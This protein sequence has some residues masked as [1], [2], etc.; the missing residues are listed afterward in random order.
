LLPR[1]I[2]ENPSYLELVINHYYYN[3]TSATPTSTTSTP[4]T[5]LTFRQL[6]ESI[7]KWSVDLDEQEKIFLNQATSVAAWDR[8]LVSNGEKVPMKTR[9]NKKFFLIERETSFRLLR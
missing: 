7:N 6:E 2:L 3:R 5:A 8:L 4:G 1:K 9:I